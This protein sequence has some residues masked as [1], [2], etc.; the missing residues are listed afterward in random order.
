[1]SRSPQGFAPFLSAPQ[2]LRTDF[3]PPSAVSVI[4]TVGSQNMT[5]LP[6]ADRTGVRTAEVA[7]PN[8]GVTYYVEHRTP[9]RSGPGQR[10]WRGDR[11]SGAALQPRHR[12]NHPP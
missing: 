1:M 5:L 6:L 2:S 4:D 12:R 8:I 9:G 10:V 3:I 7:N 11:G